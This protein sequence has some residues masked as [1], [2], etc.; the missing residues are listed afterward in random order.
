[1]LKDL[2]DEFAEQDD[3]LRF[4]LGNCFPNGG[5]RRLLLRL[6]LASAETFEMALIDWFG[7]RSP[8]QPTPLQLLQGAC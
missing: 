3:L 6:I 4:A 8:H 7:E 5:E 1:M 2:H